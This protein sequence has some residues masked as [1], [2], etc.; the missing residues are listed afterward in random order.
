MDL[1]QMEHREVVIFGKIL[2][3]SKFIEV[4][5]GKNRLRAGEISLLFSLNNDAS[6]LSMHSVFLIG[7]ECLAI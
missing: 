3:T 6:S 1:Q 4:F 2:V 5:I 7:R